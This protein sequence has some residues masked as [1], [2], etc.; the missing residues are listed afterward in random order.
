MGVTERR[1]REKEA[2]RQKIVEAAS[3]LFVEQGFE[4]V[5]I[6]R[7]ADAIEYSPAT[8]YLYFKDK[9]DL[10]GAICGD[11]FTEMCEAIKG[12]VGSRGGDPLASLRC[13]LR[14]YIDFG[15]A[16]P[17][18]Y[19]VLFGL[20][21][22]ARQAAVTPEQVASSADLGQQAFGFLRASVARSME[23]GAIAPGNVETT[24]QVAWMFVH[25][26][27]SLLIAKYEENSPDFPWLD[28]EHLVESAL[29]LL[30]AGLKSGSLRPAQGVKV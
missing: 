24:S 15:V 14:A 19:T 4:N 27:T 1:A 16:H 9:A 21:R 6:R 18:H 25:G 2:L 26:V 22:A 13:G 17:H 10:I 11:T 28:K 7:I 29:D 3:K 20:P 5:S 30:T 12:A 23:A 8:I